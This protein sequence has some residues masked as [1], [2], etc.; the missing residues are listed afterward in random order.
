MAYEQTFA[1]CK[2]GVLQR[3]LLGE[4]IGR[5][6]R[7]GLQ[8]MA[9]KMLMLPEELCRTHYAE[10]KGK[11]FYESLVKYMISGPVVTM[12]LGGENA[13]A[14]LRALCGATNPD[15]AQP[16][17]IRGDY[18]A[19]TQMNIVHASD[20]SQSAKREIELFF[21]LGEISEYEDGNRHWV[22]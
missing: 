17:T 14:Q 2:P 22:S 6:E 9:L 21:E 3:R 15:N 10:H 20:S 1:M 7:K 12:V 5:V 13:I 16:G 4:I 11:P 8:I 19:I 18:A